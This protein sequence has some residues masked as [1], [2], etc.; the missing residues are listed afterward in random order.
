M[1][2][3]YTS[4]PAE[5]FAIAH[6]SS[7]FVLAAIVLARKPAVAAQLLWNA[8]IF[9]VALQPFAVPLANGIGYHPSPE[10]AHAWLVLSGIALTVGTVFTGRLRLI[11]TS[12]VLHVLLTLGER[13]FTE[14][15]SELAGLRLCAIG[16]VVGLHMRGSTRPPT[17]PDPLPRSHVVDDAFLFVT[18]TGV[19]AAVAHFVLRRGIDSADEWA[20]TFQAAIFAKLRAFSHKP[21]CSA[22]LQNFWVFWKDERVFS[23]YPPGWPLVIAPF[24]ALGVPWLAAPV[25]HGGLA[26][27]VARLTRRILHR[28]GSNGRAIRIAGFVA[29]GCVATGGMTIVNAASR[30]PHTFVC[31]AF[32]LA[33]EAALVA[34]EAENRHRYRAAVVV[35]VVLALVTGARPLDGAA[36]GL[37]LAVHALGSLVTRRLSWSAAAL[38]LLGFFVVFGGQL[39]ILRLQLG[40]WFKT[41]YTLTSTFHPW[42][43][44]GISIPNPNEFRFGVP[45]AT[46]AYCWWPVT[47]AAGL[48]GIASLRGEGRRAIR[49][50]SIAVALLLIGYSLQEMGRGEDFGYGP[51]YEMPAIVLF[52]V[53]MGAVLGPI[54]A[55]ARLGRTRSALAAGIVGLAIP[56]GVVRLVPLL[57]PDTYRDVAARNVVFDAIKRHGIHKAVV[58]VRERQT[59]SAALDLTQNLPVDLYPNQDVLVVRY[60]DEAEDQCV[61]AA[62]PD[63]T[64]YALKPGDPLGLVP[65]PAPESP[66][67]TQAP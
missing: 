15:E 10:A 5:A 23:Q 39:V 44:F 50:L 13:Y 59:I 12:T 37:G 45:L 52:A 63:R 19:A 32:A 64:F 26:V 41:G 30:F 24:V 57:Y 21:Q 46:G 18:M 42:V 6:T 3:P 22:A 14:S 25:A 2:T 43:G 54:L 9:L 35:G 48:A 51:R 49:V 8:A 38:A 33:T 4:N 65:E 16:L 28:S 58:T 55:E 62:F 56:A 31:M 47:F 36:L 60:V 1:R 66:T 67:E 61:R 53:G 34:E 27:A 17:P 29:G 40:A 11:V 20:Y 7:A